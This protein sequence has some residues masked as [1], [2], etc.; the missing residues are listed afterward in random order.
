LKITVLQT[1]FTRL[2]G[3]PPVV[4]FFEKFEFFT[5]NQQKEKK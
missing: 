2:R 3:R 1:S 5:S 4:Y